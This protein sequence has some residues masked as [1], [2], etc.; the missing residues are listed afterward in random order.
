[1][2]PK[3]TMQQEG[4]QKWHFSTFLASILPPSVFLLYLYQQNVFYL[5]F[6]HVFVAIVIFTIGAVVLQLVV[7]KVVKSY[8]AAALINNIFWILFFTI[9]IPYRFLLDLFEKKVDILTPFISVMSVITI[10]TLYLTV[11]YKNKLQKQ[12]IFKILTIFWLTVFAI[13]ASYSAIYA[14]KNNSKLSAYD[15]NN[16]KTDF[17]V[18]KSLPNPNIYWLFMDG[19]LG[20][21]AM[22]HFFNDAQPEFIAQLTERGFIINREAQFEA[23]QRTTYCIPALMCPYYYDSFFSVKLH[24]WD[25][26]D[27]EQREKLRRSIKIKTDFACFNNELIAAFSKKGYQTYAIAQSSYQYFQQTDVKYM[28]GK[29]IHCGDVAPDILENIENLRRGRIL[30]NHVTILGRMK[31]ILD[32]L[33]EKYEKKKMNI[34]DIQNYYSQTSEVFKA[35]YG[36]SYQGDDRWYLNA[37]VD[38]M[39]NSTGPTLTILHDSKAHWPF[40]YDEHGKIIKRRERE[41]MDVYNYPLQHHFTNS[42]VI[43]YIDFIL[44]AD[45]NS[46]IILQSDHGLHSDV[47]RQI[48]ISKYGNNNYNRQLMQNQT[49]SAVRIPD[50]GNEQ[51]IDPLNI[52]RFLVN[53]YVGENYQL[54]DTKDIIK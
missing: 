17:N 41:L 34:T 4:T 15:E 25:I 33:F 1:M 14:L 54:L 51:P 18:D 12:E 48:F 39:N 7:S 45:P 36:E 40:V 27:Y 52:T 24:N 16:H 23:L 28:N 3:K 32:R 38:I 6:W 11:K 47:S 10:I 2:D 21:K 8:G 37:L 44:N 35:F 31:I 43:S 42:I 26:N 49:I 50:A 5:S 30:F 29:K 46:V 13:N 22:E 53:R 19:M 20:F 9:K